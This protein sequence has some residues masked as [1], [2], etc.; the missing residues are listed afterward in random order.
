MSRSSLLA[1]ALPLAITV[2][3]GC[4]S[5]DKK[6]TTAADAQASN[7][8]KAA[9]VDKSRCEP[10]GKKVVEMDLNGDKKP[11]V[12][13]FYVKVVENGAQV[14]VLSCKEVDLNSD[15]K[16]DEWVYYDAAGNVAHEEFDLDFD[17]KIDM[18]TFRQ[19]GKIVREELDTN[20]DGKTD[21]WKF[22]ENDKLTRIERSSKANGRVDVWEYYEGGKLDRIGYD[23]TG[24]GRVNRWER[25]AEEAPDTKTADGSAPATNAGPTVPGSTPPPASKPKPVPTVTPEASGK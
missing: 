1:L 25:A 7:Q 16:K 22:Y 8:P 18:Q 24:S 19:Q 10:N 21:V 20:Y 17:G 14:D 2:A 4:A 9:A 3:S 11:D 12:W 15:G 13:M 5:Q 6:T 23:T